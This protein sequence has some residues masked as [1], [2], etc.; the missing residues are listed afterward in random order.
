[1]NKIKCQICGK[2]KP[3]DELIPFGIFNCLCQ[4]C[5]DKQVHL[6]KQKKGGNTNGMQ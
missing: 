2:K 6:K 4:S 1:M 5:Y 3:F